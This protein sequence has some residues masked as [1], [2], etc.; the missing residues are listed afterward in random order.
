MS[1]SSSL[2]YNEQLVIVIFEF[3]CNKI[4]LKSYLQHIYHIRIVN[5]LYQS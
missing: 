4:K 5:I 1:V 3:N 2:D